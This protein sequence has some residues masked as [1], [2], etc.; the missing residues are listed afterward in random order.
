VVTVSAKG[1]VRVWNALTAEPVTPWLSHSAG[2]T[3]SEFSSDGRKLVTASE[4]R[5]ARVWDVVTGQPL[6]PPL[7]HPGR[8]G[9]ASF[10]PDG[11]LVA[12]ASDDGSARVWDVTTGA[13]ALPLLT[14]RA[15]VYEALFSPD[16]RRVVSVGRDQTVRIWSLAAIDWPLEDLVLLG[17]LLTGRQIDDTGALVPLGH[18]ASTLP[19][20]ANPREYLRRAW[21]TLRAAH[22]N[23]C[24]SAR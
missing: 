5:T 22:P 11:C 23:D 1:T 12:T 19:A 9:R 14:H 6:T 8:V 15:F 17:H 24:A 7:P 18:T 16:G 10:S 20:Q 21:E 13:L 2:V 4:D 3:S